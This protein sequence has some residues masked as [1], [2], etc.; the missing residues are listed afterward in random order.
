MGL[1]FSRHA[2]NRMRA[3]GLTPEGVSSIVRRGAPIAEDRD[4][5]KR[6]EGEIDGI[7]VRVVIA[8]DRPE[9]VVTVYGRRR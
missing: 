9:L 4:G 2:R 1:R 8:V 7:T 3:L 5:R 6:Y